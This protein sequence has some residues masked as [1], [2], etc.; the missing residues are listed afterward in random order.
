MKINTVEMFYIVIVHNDNV[1]EMVVLK[2]FMYAID[3]NIGTKVPNNR[4]VLE[5]DQR[6]CCVA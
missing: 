3:K 6:I 2:M 5:V 4:G 1:H